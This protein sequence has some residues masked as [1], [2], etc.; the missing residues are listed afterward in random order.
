MAEIPENEYLID[1]YD[2]DGNKEVFEHL[3]TVMY[4][5]SEYMVFIPYNDDETD[6][7]EIVIFKTE[8]DGNGESALSQ[9][10]DSDILSGVYEVFRE[11][12]SDQ[13]D[14]DD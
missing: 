2:E 13:F 11:R 4:K 3:D 14:F 10:V 6:V 8:D 5:G 7:D 12:N 1:L 9:V